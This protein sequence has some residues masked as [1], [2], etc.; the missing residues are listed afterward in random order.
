MVKQGD[1]IGAIG[2]PLAAPTG[3]HLHWGM[4]CLTHRS[5]TGVGADMGK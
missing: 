4:S 5:V 2:M 1:V 3:P